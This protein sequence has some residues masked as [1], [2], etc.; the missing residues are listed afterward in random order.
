MTQELP[1]TSGHRNCPKQ[2]ND[3]GT[4]EYIRTQELPKTSGHRNCPK[5]QHDTG[6]THNP[7]EVNVH[8]RLA[9]DRC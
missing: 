6:T 5:Q 4:T 1:K 2:Q 7:L 8:G 9:D 3:T